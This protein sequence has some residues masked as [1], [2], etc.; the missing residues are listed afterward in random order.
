MAIIS[1]WSKQNKWSLQ[2]RWSKTSNGQIKKWKT[3]EPQFCSIGIIPTIH[4]I[5]NQ[6]VETDLT[7]CTKI[8]GYKISHI[9]ELV[10]RNAHLTQIQELIYQ[11]LPTNEPPIYRIPINSFVQK[12]KE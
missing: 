2:F 12:N 4:E 10:A 7:K 6:I 5:E 8:L 9:E 1:E 3:L 11:N